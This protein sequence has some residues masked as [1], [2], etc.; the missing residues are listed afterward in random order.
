MEDV[1]Y[2]S[3]RKYCRGM[4]EHELLDLILEYFAIG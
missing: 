2:V 4:S 3:V 1:F